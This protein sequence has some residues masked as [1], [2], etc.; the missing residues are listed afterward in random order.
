MTRSNK[1]RSKVRKRNR[2]L[3]PVGSSSDHA[4]IGSDLV[5]IVVGWNKGAQDLYGYTAEEMIGQPIAIVIP[6]RLHE[7]RLQ[8]LLDICAGPLQR[9][10]ADGKREEGILVKLSLVFSPVRNSKGEIIGA[11]TIAPDITAR[12]SARDWREHLAAL[13]ESSDDAIISQSLDG[14]ITPWNSGAERLFGY[15]SS[16][17][18]GKPIEMLLSLE[19]ANEESAILARIKKGERID[20]FETAR[21]RKDGKRVDVSVTISPIVD[22]RGVIVGASKIARDIGDRK[23]AASAVQERLAA[24]L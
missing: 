15:S 20:H 11:S 19:R 5:G 2:E 6:E 13:V 12:T 8:A 7:E 1:A 21:I 16:E 22:R 3:A 23:R 18:V 17:A 24:V 14:T 9:N 4:V 10:E